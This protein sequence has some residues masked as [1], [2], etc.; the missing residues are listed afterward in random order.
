[1][2]QHFGNVTLLLVALRLSASLAGQV[3]PAAETPANRTAEERVLAALQ[4]PDPEVRAGAAMYLGWFGDGAHVAPITALRDDADPMVR[5]AALRALTLLADPASRGLFVGIL[6]RDNGNFDA[7]LDALRGLNGIVSAQALPSA[8]EAEAIRD[9]ATCSCD[10]RVRMFALRLLARCGEHGLTEPICDL[11][12]HPLRRDLLDQLT[13]VLSLVED[14][15]R[16]RCLRALLEDR[17]G[18]VRHRAAAALVRLGIASREERAHLLPDFVEY[19]EYVAEN[20]RAFRAA[21]AEGYAAVDER[22]FAAA[23][24]EAHVVLVGESHGDPHVRELQRRLIRQLT[25]AWEGDPL[26]VGNETGVYLE[27]DMEM[28]GVV[29]LAEENGWQSLALEPTPDPA[30]WGLDWRQRDSSAVA[31]ISAWRRAHPKGHMVVLYGARRVLGHISAALSE[32]AISVI[33]TTMDPIRGAIRV[34]GDR[35]DPCGRVFAVGKAGNVFF[36]PAQPLAEIGFGPPFR[37]TWKPL[38]DWLAR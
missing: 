24:A 38:L 36:V 19:G 23:L 37:F 6:A 2:A 17:S 26:C 34:L 32:P 18:L 15:H 13:E 20:A 3:P 30:L 22:V 1:M 27:E 35:P 31:G 14:I 7:Q 5:K 21:A 11:L 33:T 9:A 8:T 16:A 25:D 29:D 28:R 10:V 12:E 4:A